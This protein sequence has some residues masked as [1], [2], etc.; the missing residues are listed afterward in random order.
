MKKY[1]DESD[2][3]LNGEGTLCIYLLS[4]YCVKK[5]G[6]E[7]IG[8]ILLH[9]VVLVM[10]YCFISPWLTCIVHYWLHSCLLIHVLYNSAAKKWHYYQKFHLFLSIIDSCSLGV[11][12]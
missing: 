9:L 7:K 8:M 1:E 4:V 10:S 2:R 5:F 11:L 3:L 6:F 12:S